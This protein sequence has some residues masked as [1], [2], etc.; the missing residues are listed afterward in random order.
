T[1]TSTTPCS[2]LATLGTSLTIIS[3]G[4]NP[5]T[6]DQLGNYK[7]Y[8][9]PGIYTIQ[10]Y[11]PQVSSPLVQTDVN[12]GPS[13]SANNTFTGNNIFIGNN[14]FG[15][16]NGIRIVDGTKFTTCNAAATDPGATTVWIPPT[17]VGASC[18]TPLPAGILLW[19]MRNSTFNQSALGVFTN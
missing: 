12:V 3:G 17:Y 14:T 4:P 5:L 7:F 19:D 15:L 13:L 1:N 2:P 11:G 18:T 9:A 16:F 6:T 8:A 10:I